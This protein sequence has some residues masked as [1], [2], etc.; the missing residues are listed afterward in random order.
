[1][2]AVDACEG[3][4]RNLGG[5]TRAPDRP[6]LGVEPNLGMLGDPLAVFSGLIDWPVSRDT[7]FGDIVESRGKVLGAPPVS[8]DLR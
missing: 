2:L 8:A 5:F 7:R 1:M 6:G 3:G 4:A